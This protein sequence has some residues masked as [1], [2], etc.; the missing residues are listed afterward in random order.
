M[1]NRKKFNAAMAEKGYNQ[2]TTAKALEMSLPTFCRRL[3]TGNF[4]TNEVCELIKILDIKNP[5]E[6]FFAHDVT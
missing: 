3:K 2:K 6:I 4:R 5:T 1:L